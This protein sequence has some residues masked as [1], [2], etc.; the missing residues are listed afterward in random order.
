MELNKRSLP[1]PTPTAV[2]LG[3]D[4][5]FNSILGHCEKDISGKI[6]IEI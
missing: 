5:L 3:K 4:L 2:G 1:K 6:F